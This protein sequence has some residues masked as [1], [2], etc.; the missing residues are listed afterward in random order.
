MVARTKVVFIKYAGEFIRCNLPGDADWREIKRAVSTRVDVPVGAE[1]AALRA[2]DGSFIRCAQDVAP[3]ERVQVEFRYTTRVTKSE[4]DEYAPATPQLPQKILDT[5]GGRLE[6]TG[7]S[8]AV[9]GGR[10]AGILGAN[11]GARGGLHRLHGRTGAV[12]IPPLSLPVR[13]EEEARRQKEEEQRAWD[14]LPEAEREAAEA[15]NWA[16]QL[17]TSARE[18]DEIKATLGTSFKGQ[19]ESGSVRGSS[20]SGDA[21][22]SGMAVSTPRPLDPPDSARTADTIT[23]GEWVHRQACGLGYSAPPE[24]GQLAWDSSTCPRVQ[25]PNTARRPW[26]LP[27][28]HDLQH[29]AQSSPRPP[30]SGPRKRPFPSSVRKVE[31]ARTARAR[32]LGRR[33][34]APPKTTPRPPP[35]SETGGESDAATSVSAAS[36]RRQQ[37]P[38]EEPSS[39]AKATTVKSTPG[40]AVQNTPRVYTSTH[41]E[42]LKEHTVEITWPPLR[43]GRRES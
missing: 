17:I 34:A 13:P 38:R 33:N 19:P 30:G 40:G 39:T 2:K 37:N 22:S 7:A 15:Q 32:A 24:V 27:T 18:N 20:R 31:E 25:R 23:Y 9:V 28:V 21:A 26:E 14:A 5:L 41:G 8:T 43:S 3:H 16:S 42:L 12:S 1:V 10:R 29:A 11:L 36:C 35:G 4:A 6:F